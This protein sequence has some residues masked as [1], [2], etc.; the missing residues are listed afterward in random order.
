VESGAPPG[1]PEGD[2]PKGPQSP[3]PQPPGYA[4][5]P[6]PGQA[7]WPAPEAPPGPAGPQAPPPYPPA[8]AGW[9]QPPAVFGGLALAS[10]GT[11]AGA[12][13][14]D[15]LVVLGLWLTLI[16]PGVVI[17]AAT[18]ADAVGVTLLIVGALAAL[19]IGIL[20]APFFMQRSGPHNG[21]SLGKQWVGI[22]VVRVSGEPFGWGWG[23]LRE[24]V[25]K[26]IALGVASSIAGGLTFF[27]LGAGGF[28][29]Y[30]ADY[31]W[32]LWDDQN[33]AVHDMIAETRVVQA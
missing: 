25:L 27:L 5:P 10:W 30:L 26:G 17:T 31:L 15:T 11:R 9:Q 29:P 8:P 6:P 3:A 16:A 21:Q 24:F 12:A 7:P 33:R 18:D 4:Q 19:V 28:G 14:L 32:P 2:Q 13:V 23:L 1:P 22:R 20:Y